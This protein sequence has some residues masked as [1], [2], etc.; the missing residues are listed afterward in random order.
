M[1][2][3]LSGGVKLPV[4]FEMLKEDGSIFDVAFKVVYAR[5]TKQL[6]KARKKETTILSK[7]IDKEL[8]RLQKIEEIDG[9]EVDQADREALNDLIE[10]M[11]DLPLKWLE[12]DI[13]N[14]EGLV[15]LDATDVPFSKKQLKEL[16]NH[17][18]FVVG[19]KTVWS[20]ATGGV[21]PEAEAEADS[22]N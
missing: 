15:D 20:Q 7:K 10:D 19:F 6:K 18:P 16:L 3:L 2:K 13:L 14:W 5:A 22:K 11:G 4:E 9:G 1:M 12:K 21:L 17:D 8:K